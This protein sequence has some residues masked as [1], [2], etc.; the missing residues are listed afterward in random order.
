MCIRDRSSLWHTL[1][2]HKPTLLVHEDNQ[3]MIRV[4]DT[5][6]NPTMRYLARTHRISVAWLHERFRSN[7]LQLVYESTTKMCRYLHQRIL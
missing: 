7:E 2:P 5:G 3:A 1:L 6:K 4:I